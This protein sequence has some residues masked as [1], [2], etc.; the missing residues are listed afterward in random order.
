MSEKWGQ[1][2]GESPEI[3]GDP[4]ASIRSDPIMTLPTYANDFLADWMVVFRTE[5]GFDVFSTTN[6]RHEKTRE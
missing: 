5:S 3:D 6:E 4:Y 2:I 1:T